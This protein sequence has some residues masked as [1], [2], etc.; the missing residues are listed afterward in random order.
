[1]HASISILG[2]HK[3][4]PQAVLENSGPGGTEDFPNI[5]SKLLRVDLKTKILWKKFGEIKVQI[6]G[7]VPNLT[8]L[9]HIPGDFL[10]LGGSFTFKGFMFLV[11]CE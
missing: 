11:V 4:L 1:M 8:G 6:G 7:F 3:K 5:C 9:Y 2:H 10:L